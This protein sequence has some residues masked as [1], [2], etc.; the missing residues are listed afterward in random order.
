MTWTTDKPTE[1]GWY[2]YERTNGSGFREV[3]HVHKPWRD[4]LVRFAGNTHTYFLEE[5]PSD[6][7][8]CCVEEP[9]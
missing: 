6:S 9:E 7:R 4:L 8:W 2:W 5:I 3:V 1:P